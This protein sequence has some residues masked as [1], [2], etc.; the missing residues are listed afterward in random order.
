SFEAGLVDLVNTVSGNSTCFDSATAPHTTSFSDT[1]QHLVTQPGATTPVTNLGESKRS[2]SKAL[3]SRPAATT[4]SDLTPCDPTLL[5]LTC[6]TLSQQRRM[7]RLTKACYACGK[8]DHGHRS[9][10]RRDPHY[11]H[12]EC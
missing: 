12:A 8:P 7:E 6:N 9:C 11:W 2:S 5:T 10:C 1:S 4:P 3:V